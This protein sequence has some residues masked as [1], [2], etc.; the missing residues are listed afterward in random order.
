MHYKNL[1]Y[2]ASFV[3]YSITGLAQDGLIRGTVIDGQ[4]KEPIPFVNV[5]LSNSTLGAPSDGAGTFLFPSPRGK[6]ELIASHIAYNVFSTNILVQNDTLNIVIELSLN[7]NQLDEITVKA[8]LDNEWNDQLARFRK[9]FFGN[10]NSNLCQI[11]NPWVIEFSKD[12]DELSAHAPIPLEIENKA[13]GYR[14][15]FHLTHFHSKTKGY[16]IQGHSFFEPLIETDA[17]QKTFEVN[18]SKAYYNSTQS[19]FKSILNR[20][21]KKE[22]YELYTDKPG[23][24]KLRER[25]N[26]FSNEV[27]KTLV[28]FSYDENTERSDHG[29]LAIKLKGRLEVHHVLDL[30]SKKVYKDVIYPV[31]WIESTSG[32]IK[33]DSLGNILNPSDLLVS[34]HLDQFRVASLLP[35]NYR[36]DE[37]IQQSAWRNLPIEKFNRL[38]EKVFLHTNKG[39]Y[40]P[41][42]I[43]WF[44]GYMKYSNPQ[45]QDS[46]S[47]VLYVELINH[48]KIIVTQEQFRI[49]SGRI[50]GQIILNDE[51]LPGKYYMRAYTRW[52]MNYPSEDL[53]LRPLPILEFNEI[54]HP[55][56]KET[57]Q[58]NSGITVQGIPG[59]ENYAP[60]E[61]IEITVKVSEHGLPVAADFSVAIIDSELVDPGFMGPTIY[62]SLKPH[63][64]KSNFT[65]LKV[66]HPIEYGI[67]LS[68]TFKSEKKKKT[69]SAL[70]IMRGDKKEIAQVTTTDRG[71]FFLSG[72][73]YYDTAVFS[74]RPLD[75][76]GKINLQQK[77]IPT[78]AR[79]NFNDDY[80]IEKVNSYYRLNSDFIVED[81]AR[82]LAEVLIKD[83]PIDRERTKMGVTYGKPDYVLTGEQLRSGVIGPNLTEALAGKIPGL[84]V[85]TSYDYNGVKHYNLRIRGGYSSFG[86]T[87]TIEPMVLVD[88][89]PFASRFDD[90]NTVG[91]FLVGLSPEIVDHIE[92]ITRANPL[93]GVNGTNGVIIIYTKKGAEIPNRQNVKSTNSFETQTFKVKGYTRHLEFKS[94]DYAM[95]DT[96]KEGDFRS[97]IYW[98]PNSKTDSSGKFNFSFYASDNTTTY[99]IKVIGITQDGLP[100]DSE[101]YLRISK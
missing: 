86:Y 37:I 79:I 65:S 15:L 100:F 82:L 72:F 49:D 12:K 24:E 17:T 56:S 42:D 96:A 9:D 74:I 39:Y 99:K 34:G 2:L 63:G 6:Y 48:E 41:G 31:S 51:L 62:E 55:K 83:T 45:L 90:Q 29:E 20:S 36:P 76:K 47:R 85:T 101:S 46:L 68:G 92:V 10:Q 16:S 71:N 98:N 80:Q 21:S 3:L 7:Q 78:L 35:A 19:I 54:L 25:S 4:S 33:L 23:Y 22:G 64:I 66:T 32:I 84:S 69:A 27:N 94:P 11:L 52:M 93:F 70:V 97:T 59:K 88:G 91:D 8:K 60:R 18:R 44:K 67:S 40:Y 50:Q 81:K 26:I 95:N 5:F 14:L 43:V 13:L 1:L 77:P 57:S 53:F 87:G 38:Q 58:V 28:K 30:A 75:A 61:K 73:N 89:V